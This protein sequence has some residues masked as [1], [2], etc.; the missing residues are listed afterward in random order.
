MDSHK[1]SSPEQWRL[2]DILKYR[3][4]EHD[5]EEILHS[6]LTSTG[7]LTWNGK[8]EIVYRGQIYEELTL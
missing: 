2:E 7:I 5:A 4:D 6:I 8:G 3:D 1:R